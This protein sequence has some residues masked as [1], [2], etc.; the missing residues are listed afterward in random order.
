VPRVSPFVGL[1]FDRSRV[2]P[3]ERVT[4]PPYDVISAQE[5]ARLL[6]ASPYN[7]IGLDLG[8]EPGAPAAEDRY[9]RAAEE[10][11]RWRREGALVTTASEAYYPFEV[12][13][14]LHGRRRQIRG[15][16]CAVE[17]EDLGG[18]IVPHEQTMTGPVQDRLRLLRAIGANLSCIYAVF[19]GPNRPLSDWLREHTAGEPEASMT[20]EDGVEHR[21]W[22]SDPGPEVAGWL[23]R[24]SLMIADGHHRYATALRHRN[25]MRAD[26]GAGPW[27]AAMML[28]VDATL[29][30][31]P[32]LPYHRIQRSGAV[33]PGGVRV[34]DLEEV[35]ESVDDDKLRYGVAT[36]HEGALVHR[37]VELAGGP[38][39]VSRLHEQTLAG[40][41]HELG[42]TPDA[43]AAEEAVRGGEAVAAYFLPPTAA[44]TIRSVVDR[45]ERLPQ[46]S[47]YFWPKPRTGLVIRPHREI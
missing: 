40:L 12:R 13:F 18:D 4:A 41:E 21:L 44:A 39:I 37:L 30:E 34:R 35:L 19:R 17:L 43:V 11:A 2:G 16:I 32:V 28:L 8:R 3:L 7:V 15:L 1:R 14:S 29:E 38:P 27:D 36:H 26:R 10:L 33:P 47:T 9:A 22:Q 25:E 42:F 31:P 20:D 6:A 24:E 46:K 23:E 5:H 45:G